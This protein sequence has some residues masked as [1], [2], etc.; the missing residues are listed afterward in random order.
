[1]GIFL[2]IIFNLI[3]I[4]L[5]FEKRLLIKYPGNE[6]SR[7]FLPPSGLRNLHN[8]MKRRAEPLN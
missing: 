6:D 1:M 4:V 8:G 5:M 3:E 2:N 7:A